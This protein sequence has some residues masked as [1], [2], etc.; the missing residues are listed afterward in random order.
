MAAQRVE[1]ERELRGP[2]RLSN[3]EIALRNAYA[4]R[5]S[6]CPARPADPCEEEPARH[7]SGRHVS[8]PCQQ[9]TS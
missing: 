2:A 5:P 4:G 7:P 1:H 6:H 8:Q 9:Q 3:F